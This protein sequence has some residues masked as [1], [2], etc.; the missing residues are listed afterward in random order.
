MVREFKETDMHY[1]S[2]LC[3]HHSQRR[4]QRF[5]YTEFAEGNARVAEKLYSERFPQSDA[6]DGRLCDNLHHNLCVN[7]DHY[8]AIGIVR[9]TY[10]NWPGYP[11]HCVPFM[12]QTVLNTVRRNPRTTLEKRITGGPPSQC[13]LLGTDPYSHKL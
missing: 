7:M 8:D 13:L 4:W 6:P 9:A 11:T 5:T 1:C 2:L 3:C 12:V 10:S